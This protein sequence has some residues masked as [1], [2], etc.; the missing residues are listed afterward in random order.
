MVDYYKSLVESADYMLT[1][2]SA[3]DLILMERCPHF[4]QVRR[5]LMKLRIFFGQSTDCH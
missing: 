2:D 4:S 5:R 1:D 3:I